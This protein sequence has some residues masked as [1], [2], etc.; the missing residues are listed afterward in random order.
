MQNL[1][2][3][4]S[5]SSL[6]DLT[7][8]YMINVVESEL[9][10]VTVKVNILLCHSQ[11]TVIYGLSI[12]YKRR[13]KVQLPAAGVIIGY[14]NYHVQKPCSKCSQSAIKCTILTGSFSIFIENIVFANL[15]NSSAL[16]YY[17]RVNTESEYHGNTKQI[18]YLS[19]TNVSVVHTSGF[20]YLKMFYIVLDYFRS[21]SNSSSYPVK[22]ESIAGFSEFLS[23]Y[24]YSFIRNTNIDTMIYVESSNKVYIKI[25]NS[26]FRVNI[27]ACFLKIA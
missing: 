18:T 5:S 2:V 7:G 15:S 1:Y 24:N 26:T 9:F 10:N 3:N 14:F 20:G 19:I 23:F 12:Y 6:T 22:V 16:H 25:E 27:N 13:A 17:S 8:I 4:V 11:P 21:F